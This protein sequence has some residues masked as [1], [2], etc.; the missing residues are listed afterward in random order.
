M[1]ILVVMTN[2]LGPSGITHSVMNYHRYMDKTDM[3]IDFIAPNKVENKWRK[4][5]EDNGGRLFELTMRNR[6][7]FKYMLKLRAIMT[8][9]KYDIVHAHG[10]S[11]TLAVEML[12]AKWAGIKVRI[13]HSR[14]TTCKHRLLHGI[15]R[16]L[17]N[18]TYTHALACGTE[19]G[20][21]LFP[22][23]PFVVMPNGNDIDKFQFNKKIRDEYRKKHNLED[24]KVIGH[25]GLFND[26]KNHS[27]LIDVFAEL[28]KNK[29]GTEYFLILI[30]DGKLKS[31][32]E[33]KVRLLGIDSH[34]LF[35]GRSSNVHEWLQA[36]DLMLLP[37]LYEGLPNVVVEWQ[38]A[39]VPSI[40]SD[41]VTREVKLTDIVEF[42][43]LEGGATV[44]AEQI[45][46]TKLED[47]EAIKDIVISQINNAGFN[48]KDN[49][50]QL[51]IL[52]SELVEQS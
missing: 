6:N 51:E 15:L 20:E 33:H 47:R 44:W 38:I 7:P 31:E 43:P 41:K 49:A 21:W 45:R 2:P 27:F 18:R 12:T 1:R 9:G 16:P 29:N 11:C 39:G 37:S 32:I 23:K 40:I 17:F 24:K 26:Q 30:G 25:V 36:M 5:I 50:K 22:G 35:T 34:V 8:N 28:L 42:L 48:V 14:N 10:N 4:Q 3:V 52:Y 19:A 46:R 13:S